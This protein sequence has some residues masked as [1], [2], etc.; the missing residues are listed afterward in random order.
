MFNQRLTSKCDLNF[1]IIFD[2]TWRQIRRNARFDTTQFPGCPSSLH[3]G[4]CSNQALTEY[5]WGGLTPRSQDQDHWPCWRS[6]RPGAGTPRS[7]WG[8]P[9]P[10]S[11]T[12][13]CW[14]P[15]SAPRPRTW[16]KIRWSSGSIVTTF[17]SLDAD[18]TVANISLMQKCLNEIACYFAF[19]KLDFL[20]RSKSLISR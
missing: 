10:R 15:C 3:P 19:L 9:S 18:Q 11:C 2:K 17:C 13:S 7:R 16:S 1:V 20:S 12:A 5:R 4:K 8:H 14:A 6:S